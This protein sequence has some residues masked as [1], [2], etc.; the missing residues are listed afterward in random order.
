MG[1]INIEDVKPGMILAKDLR[2]RSGLILLSAGHEITEKHLKI[3][4][5]WGIMEAEIEGV[6]REE[7]ISRTISQIDPVLLREAEIQVREQF[8][9]ADLSNPFVNEL[10]RLLILRRVHETS[11]EESHGS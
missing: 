4:R 11:G 10:F 2:D 5:M 9:H 8:R 1:A 6:T 7:T 3:L